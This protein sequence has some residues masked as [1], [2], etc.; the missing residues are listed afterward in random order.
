VTASRTTSQIDLKIVIPPLIHAAVYRKIAQKVAELP[1]F[2]M[3]YAAIAKSLN[4]SKQLEIIEF[5]YYHKQT[6]GM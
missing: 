3:P 1:H 2:N 5:R 6:L 4:V